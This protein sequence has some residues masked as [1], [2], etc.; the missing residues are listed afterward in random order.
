MESIAN[1]QTTGYSWPLWGELSPGRYAVG[2]R[3]FIAS[4]FSRRY[5]YPTAQSFECCDIPRP[6]AIQVWYPTHSPAQTSAETDKQMGAPYMPYGDYLKMNA[7]EAH[8]EDFAQQLSEFILNSHC[9]E[10]M[11]SQLA[12]LSPEDADAFKHFLQMPT[13]CVANAPLPE[14][15]FPLLIYHA[16]LGGSIVDNPTLLEFIASHGYMVATSSFQP[17]HG[18]SFGV[19]SN[20]TR[21][22]KDLSY[23]L[24]ILCQRYPVNAEK[25]AVIGHSFG[26]SAV[27]GFA[28]EPSSAVKAVISL[29]STREWNTAD[30]GLFKGTEERLAAATERFIAPLMVVSKATQSLSFQHYQKLK[31]AERYYL[32]VEH[33][34]HN[35][36]VTPGIT[37]S[38]AD[39]T[40]CDQPIHKASRVICECVLAFLDHFL[41]VPCCLKA[42]ASSQDQLAAAFRK[43]DQ[44]T[45]YLSIQTAVAK[46]SL[47]AEQILSTI[48]A[49]GMDD[50]SQ[51]QQDE[52]VA[53]G[54]SRLMRVGYALQERGLYEQAAML[55]QAINRHFSNFSQAYEYLGD[56]CSAHLNDPTRAIAAYQTALDT[57]STDSTLSDLEKD[58]RRQYL[59]E[60]LHK[61]LARA[62]NQE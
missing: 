26:A 62:T 33:L 54:A 52:S 30:D 51:Q 60:D 44:E 17:V 11:G 14:T 43:I 24:Q 25:I 23:I 31:Y 19:D 39:L 16:G 9:R 6:I 27:M 7:E 59:T 48:L 13:A 45:Q 22:I 8:L 5:V 37:A 61:L 47:A 40:H 20:A 38:T 18:L 41:K 21:S 28:F 1:T 2:F 35:D 57:L 50:F 29:D 53:L 58:Y 10:E 3:S 49:K 15:A 4:D 56:I 46:S 32:S 55:Y 36:F 12:D 42:S 34:E